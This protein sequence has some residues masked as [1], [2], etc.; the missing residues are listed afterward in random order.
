MGRFGG[1]FGGFA[2]IIFGSGFAF[3]KIFRGGGFK[4]SQADVGQANTNGSK[5]AALVQLHLRG[6]GSGGVITDLALQFQIRAATARFGCRYAYFGQNFIGGEGRLIQVQVKG[7]DRNDTFTTWSVR[8][9]FRAISQHGRGF[10]VDRIR[11]RNIS[12]DGP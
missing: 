9:D 11:I 7:C 4:R 2:E 8:D 10:I 6:D 1:K 5:T 12:T 3:E